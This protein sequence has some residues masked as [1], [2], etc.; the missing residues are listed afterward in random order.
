MNQ[1]INKI[2][3]KFYFGLLKF[4]TDGIRNVFKIK[5]VETPK[6]SIRQFLINVSGVPSNSISLSDG[7]YYLTSWDRWCQIID[8]DLID[9]LVYHYDKFDCDR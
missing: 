8:F 1:D 9:Q 5:S 2:A 7:K 3:T 6:P 4:A